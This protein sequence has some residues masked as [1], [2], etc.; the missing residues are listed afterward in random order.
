MRFFHS[1]VIN[2]I[3]C[4]IAHTHMPHLDINIDH[5]SYMYADAGGWTVGRSDF[6]VITSEEIAICNY[7]R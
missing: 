4:V 5:G 7:Q 2:S 6:A 1:P 3:I